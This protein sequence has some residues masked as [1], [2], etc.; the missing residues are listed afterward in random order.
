MGTKIANISIII[1]T[2]NS[3]KFILNCLSSIFKTGFKG[4]VIIIDNNSKDGTVLMVKKSFPLI[5]IIELKENAGFGRSINL[6]ARN[7]KNKYLFFLNPDT[8]IPQYFFSKLEDFISQNKFGVIGFALV[9]KNGEAEKFSFG[10]K[11][12]FFEILK[13]K[14]FNKKTFGNEPILTDW[15]SGAAMITPKTIF[16]G[17]GGFDENLF[18]Y[19][20]DQDFCLKVK[21]IG[22][23]IYYLPKI[24]ITHFSGATWESKELQKK[25]Y[26]I[27]QNYFFKKHNSFLQYLLMRIF[28]FISKAK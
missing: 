16:D 21:N 6:A 19:F 14:F 10:R 11:T 22:H 20:E 28:R 24:K 12:T 7:L 26:Y 3:G 2:Y 9:S 23:K 1:P 17:A 18:M 25:H 15:V 5:K 13:N 27:S 8:L 4:E